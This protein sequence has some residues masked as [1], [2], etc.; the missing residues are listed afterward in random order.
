MIP[1]HYIGYNISGDGICNDELL[2]ESCCFDMGDCEHTSNS[3]TICPSCGQFDSDTLITNHQCDSFIFYESCCFDGGDCGCPTC[4]LGQDGIGDGRC[5]R[6][7][8]TDECC[9]DGGDCHCL[10]VTISFDECCPESGSSWC[11][12]PNSACPTCSSDLTPLLD[13]GCCNSQIFNDSLCCFDV[14]DCHSSV[15]QYY[16]VGNKRYKVTY[17]WPYFA[18]ELC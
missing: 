11:F 3:S 14:I 18:T 2:T 6:N 1:S 8:E 7:L 15:G 16:F 4:P 17:G 13:N 10:A 9:Y 5:D 12:P